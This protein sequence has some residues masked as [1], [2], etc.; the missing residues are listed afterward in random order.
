MIASGCGLNIRFFRVGSLLLTG[1]PDHS[2]FML[3]ISTNKQAYAQW[4][5]NHM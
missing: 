3:A 2:K 4:N 1:I 5:D